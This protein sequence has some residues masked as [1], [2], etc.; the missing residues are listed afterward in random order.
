M[1]PILYSSSSVTEGSVPT[2]YGIGALTDCIRCEASEERNGK[3][4]MTLVYP[5]NGIHADQIQYGS[6]IK[7]KPNFTDDPQLFQV[8]KIGKTMNGQFTVYCQHVSYLLS[9]KVITSG[10]AGSCTAACTL[11]TASAGGFTINT[12]K[13]VSA[14]F[15]I[16]EPS[17]VR[18]WFGGK[19]GSLLDVYGTAEWHYDNFTCSLKAHRGADR[20]VQIRY[21]KNLTQLSQEINMEN[22]C[23]GIIPFCIDE[24]KTKTVGARVATGLILDFD[25]DKAVDFSDDVDFESATP[26]LTQLAT[27]A[28]NYIA[29]NNFTDVF[30]SITLDFVQLSDLTER[31]DL[32]DTVHIYFDALGITASLKCV[33]TTWDVLNER[34][35]SCTFGDMKTSIADTIVNQQK[36]VAD[37]PSVSEMGKAIDTATKL[38]TGNLGGY[39]VMHDSDNN[40]YPDEILIMDTPDISTATNV[41]R[42]NQSGIGLSTT[43]YVGPYTTALTASGIVADAI[44]T[45]V[46]NANLIKAGV[47]EDLAQNS[48]IDM[49]T[50]VAKLFEL[51]AKSF[52]KIEDAD[53]GDMLAMLQAGSTGGLLRLYNRNGDYVIQG[54]IGSLNNDGIIDVMDGSGNVTVSLV[55]QSGHIEQTGGCVQLWSGES[56]TGSIDVI[57]AYDKYT[58]YLIYGRVDTGGSFIS[59]LIPRTMITDTN[60]KFILS[61]EAKYITFNVRYIGSDLRI[62]HNT[63]SH[64]GCLLKVY[65][66]Y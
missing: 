41:I 19:A 3:Y 45:G 26:L 4:E 52:C 66:I 56:Y 62:D 21:G 10:T 59:T 27:L 60:Q 36:E 39:V 24:T 51:V 22:L 20:G 48:Q 46:L 37:K 35:I 44:T 2:S 34:Y 9:G 29:N 47:I 7:A 31:V 5:A 53:T 16:T 49:T 50:G 58:S 63:K 1:I 14:D 13:N 32:C 6:F 38:I 65:G 43:G 8:Y 30:N 55:G 42:M 61:D 18:S 40:G 17:S 25:R 11:L 28:S 15:N 57:G 64:M 12:D 23:T 54:F 33:A